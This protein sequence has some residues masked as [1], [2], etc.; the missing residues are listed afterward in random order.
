MKEVMTYD[1]ILQLEKLN[2]ELFDYQKKLSEELRFAKLICPKKMPVLTTEPSF[3]T[4]VAYKTFFLSRKDDKLRKTIE[5]I[6]KVIRSIN[7]II[8]PMS[9]TCTP[10]INKEN[11]KD[12]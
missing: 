11:E 8:E 3:W 7:N 12:L 6:N 2:K 10:F 1:E 5:H 9:N 4:F